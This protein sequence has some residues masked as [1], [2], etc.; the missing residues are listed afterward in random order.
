MHC[1]DSSK[2][3]QQFFFTG[4]VIIFVG[5]LSVAFLN[6]TLK[7]LEWTGIFLIILGLG[8][9]GAADFLTKNNEEHG[10]N[11][12]ITGDLLIIIAQIITAVQMV[13]EEKYVAGLNIPPLQAVGWE[14]AFGCVVLGS[15]LLPF[16][17]I[18]VPPPITNNPRNVL[19]DVVDAFVQM[20]NNPWI[21]IALLGKHN[22]YQ[23]KNKRTIT[24]S[25]VRVTNSLVQIQNGHYETSLRYNF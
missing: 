11:D 14:G 3:T 25:V 21:V 22:L 1:D 9:V 20:G 6:R 4:S 13:V 5:L 16:Y 8:V 17:Y 19:E 23:N 2:Q 7:R 10:R 15:L 12:I 18:H 24:P